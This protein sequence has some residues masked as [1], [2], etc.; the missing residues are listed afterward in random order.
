[1]DVFWSPLRFLFGIPVLVVVLSILAAF[2]MV[3]QVPLFFV[4][5][6]LLTVTPRLK[7]PREETVQGVASFL[8]RFIFH[9]LPNRIPVVSR[10]LSVD[11]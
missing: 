9:W 8:A 6:P 5:R 1:M 10:S 2:L 11:P 3:L 4:V 7:A